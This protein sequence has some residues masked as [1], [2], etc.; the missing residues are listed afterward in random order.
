MQDHIFNGKFYEKEH[1]S[2]IPKGSYQQSCYACIFEDGFWLKNCFCRN[3]LNQLSVQKPFPAGDC[4]EGTI[5]NMF[6]KLTCDF[7]RGNQVGSYNE[8]C[9]DCIQIVDGFWLYNCSCDS[10]AGPVTYTTFPAGNCEYG[11]IW[12][13][14]GEL[15][16]TYKHPYARPKKNDNGSVKCDQ[17]C[18]SKEYGGWKGT[19]K[20]AIDTSTMLPI[21]CDLSRSPL[22][23]VVCLC[24]PEEER[25]YA[26]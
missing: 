17:V 1:F 15:K 9:K 20:G 7:V 19:C 10:P 13:N 26:K 24:E 22:D 3:R 11:S 18:T 16:C 21:K 25:Y 4:K 5:A 2:Q 23:K 14:M 6:G 8:S 12:N